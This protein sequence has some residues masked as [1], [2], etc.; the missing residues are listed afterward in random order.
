MI[1]TKYGLKYPFPH[2]LVH[3]VDNSSYTGDLPV[4]IADEPSM[5][6]AIVVTGLPMGED[7]R[8]IDVKRSD[9]LNV[10]FG[11]RNLS[12]GDIK[13]FG[14]SATYPVSLINQGGPVKLLRV[15]PDDATYAYSVITVEWRKDSTDNTIHVRYNTERFAQDRAL[16][17]FANRDR[18]NAAIVKS[19]ANATSDPPS[20]DPD[21]DRW[22]KRAFIVN[23][24]AGR[25]AVYNKFATTIDKTIQG[26]NPPNVRYMFSTIDTMT[27]ATVEQFA[28]SLINSENASRPDAIESVNVQVKRRVDGSSIVVPYVN[29]AAIE[30]LYNDYRQHLSEM[31]MQNVQITNNRVMTPDYIA[32][33][34]VMLNINIF[35][36]IFGNYIY[37][38]TDDGYK[39][40]FYQVDMRSSDIAELGTEK[41]I[42]VLKK[43]DDPNAGNP[44]K[45]KAAAYQTIN[46]LLLD[47]FTAGITD[48]GDSVHLGDV[49]VYSGLASYMNPYFYIVA[50]VNQY[51]GAVSTINVNTLKNLT[52]LITFNKSTGTWTGAETDAGVQTSV[53]ATILKPATNSVDAFGEVLRTALKN[54]IVKGG[55]TVVV[56]SVDAGGIQTGDF[57]LY[58]VS[59]RPAT[60]SVEAVDIVKLA[61]D[62]DA[63]WNANWTDYV[64]MYQKKKIYYYINWNE[65]NMSAGAGNVIATTSTDLAWT[66]PGSTVIDVT[67]SF[68][69]N[70]EDSVYINNYDI[71]PDDHTGSSFVTTGRTQVVGV[72]TVID[73]P[74]VMIR[75]D[76]KTDLMGSEYDI[77]TLDETAVSG[78]KFAHDKQTL[79]ADTV[80]FGETSTSG[81]TKT[82]TVTV[83]NGNSIL[84]TYDISVPVADYPEGTSLGIAFVSKNGEETVFTRPGGWSAA[85][86]ALN[87]EAPYGVHDFS[88]AEATS[89]SQV[90][91]TLDV[92]PSIVPSAD[93]G[94]F[95]FVLMGN[96]TDAYVSYG[97]P[98]Y[99][100]YTGERTGSPKAK[101]LYEKPDSTYVLTNDTTFTEA[102]TYYEQKRDALAKQLHKP[103]PATKRSGS[104]AG[105]S[106]LILQIPVGGLTPVQN[107]NA[108][109]ESIDRYMI[110]S[111]QG[112]FWRITKEEYLQIPPNYYSSIYGTNI[113]SS[114]GG[115]KLE[116]GSTGFFDNKNLSEVQFKWLYSA[117]LVK[118]YRGS[119]DPR[120]MSP[121]RVPAK[122]LFD[123]GTNTIVGQTILP[124]LTYSVNDK[125]QA[126]TIFTEDEKESVMYDKSLTANLSA[127]DDIDVKQAMYDMMIHRVYQGLPEDKRPIGPGSGLSLHLD[128]GVTDAITAKLI[129]T[130]FEKRFDNPNASWDIGGYVS[131]ADGIPYTYVKRIVDNL[132]SH[133]KATSVNK[134]FVGKFTTIRSDEFVSYFPDIDATDWDLSEL[135]YNSGGNTWVIDVN[136]NLYRRSQRTLH[137]A[138]STS[139]L[140]QENNMRTLSQLVYLLQN[141]LD[142]KLF[143]YDD[144][145][146]LKTIQDEVNVM[147][148]NWIGE[149]VQSLSIEFE[150]DINIDGG[151]IVI[152]I[153]NVTFRGLILRVPIIVNVNRRVES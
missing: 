139:D 118:A 38:G 151:D 102:K 130:S 34:N 12:S 96:G 142:S 31:I 95:R 129:N 19:Y 20:T 121:V 4:V 94:S 57:E 52:N 65:A 128:A 100:A 116:D 92:S 1:E 86:N 148:S 141:K 143:E 37:N 104:G 147:F 6:G 53:L 41:R 81:G 74:P 43:D 105:T 51:T 44:D 5:Y 60:S 124:Y 136:G 61:K 47:G 42:Y 45:E 140:L 85:T 56:R 32:K 76:E 87:T 2:T 112:S 137:R 7:R 131:S 145:A 28:A 93:A 101:G 91:R 133:C 29:E 97:D 71:N 111:T 117:L 21:G 15:T 115:I 79:N 89:T 125:I 3:I 84:A 36:A 110:S 27:N 107:E 134:P 78:Y 135:L 122:Y 82:Q 108:T 39:L 88:Y 68:T 72:K 103:I 46:E 24:S 22:K 70:Y 18:L 75:D 50:S 127:D 150:R 26:K 14:Q 23:I 113:T 73:K 62:T 98:Y 64:W 106:A 123:G 153:V 146:V 80:I 132:I 9:V 16:A 109:P 48:S 149:L 83:K 8:V 90:T 13:K 11:L 10:A 49:Y 25:G 99:E 54:G 77:I 40:P 120:I 58:Y 144:D 119:I 69:N 138:S 17:N 126:S 114:D 63:V 33:V 152:C 35:D 67:G 59:S 55:E 66:K 30:E